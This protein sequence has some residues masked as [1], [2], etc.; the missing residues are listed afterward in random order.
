LADHLVAGLTWSAHERTRIGQRLA[1]LEGGVG[2]AAA[3][4]ALLRD[5]SPADAQSICRSL[6]CTNGEVHSVVWLLRSL[7][8]VHDPHSLELADL[9]L[10]MA[11]DEFDDL[12]ALLRSDLSADGAGLG[13]WDALM[14]RARVIPRD[15]V[16]PAPF[17][18]GQDVLA[19]GVPAGPDI[20]R[21]LDAVYR[22]QLNETVRDRS[23][24]IVLMDERIRSQ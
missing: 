16:A 11:D 18:T 1:S 19:R 14:A 9:K 4:A 5:R 20:G 24:A 23:A 15:A 13:P 7:P 22:A 3:L 2:F 10:L 8:R 21:I 12:A 6:R 17:I